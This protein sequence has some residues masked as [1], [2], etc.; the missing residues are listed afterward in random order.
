MKSAFSIEWLKSLQP[1]KQ[2]K[3][4][5]N[6]PLHIKGK[7]LSAKLSKELQ[8]KHNTRSIRVRT[9]DKVTIM[10]GQFK[11]K[12]GPVE[13]VDPQRERVYVKGAELSKKEGGKVPYPIHPSN[14]LITTPVTDDKKRFKQKTSSKEAGEVK[15]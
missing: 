13:R 7:F 12:T 4:R 9:G 8:K 2:R 11:G 1:R 15:E 14:L 3:F 5:Q 10:R 6:A